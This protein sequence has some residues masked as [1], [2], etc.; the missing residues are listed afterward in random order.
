MRGPFNKI[1][2]RMKEKGYTQ[3]EICR[4]L[5]MTQSSFSK[6]INGRANFTYDEMA[7]LIKT[8]FIADEEISEFFFPELLRKRN[9]KGV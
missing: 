4:Q 9:S 1:E 7:A 6:K 3:A 2:G 8:L 5:K